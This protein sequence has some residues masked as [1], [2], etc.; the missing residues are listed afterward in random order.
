MRHLHLILVSLLLLLLSAC[1]PSG[2]NEIIDQINVALDKEGA[3]EAIA[4]H[5][6]TDQAII[7]VIQK[8]HRAQQAATSQTAV[9]FDTE[10]IFHAADSLA[11]QI[12]SPGLSIWTNTQIGFYYYR[13]SQLE[14]A[15]PYFLKSSKRIA[16]TAYKALIDPADCFV[17]NAYFFGNIGDNVQSID[18]LSQALLFVDTS[19]TDYA[20]IQF[21]L[22]GEYLS[23]GDYT[24]AEQH[25]IRSKNSAKQR[26]PIRYAKALGE[27]ALLAMEVGDLAEAETLLREDIQLS[28]AHGDERNTMFARIRLARIYIE[29]RAWEAAKLQLEKAEEYVRSRSN[30]T[31]FD[32]EITLL[33]LTI[34]T[35]LDDQAAQ[36]VLHRHLQSTAELLKETDGEKAVMRVNLAL[37]RARAEN[38]IL[39]Q[40][41]KLQQSKMN[42]AALLAVCLLLVVIALFL[43]RSKKQALRLQ[44]LKFERAVTKFQLDKMKSESKYAQAQQTI[45]SYF[46]FLKERNAAIDEL[47]AVVEQFQKSS[48]TKSK[49]QRQKLEQLMEEHLMTEE[50]WNR[51]KTT[52]IM[53][54]AEFYTQVAQ[55]LPSI[56]ESQLRIVLLQKLGLNNHGMANLLGVGQDSIKKAKQRLR[57]KYGHRYDQLFDS[58]GLETHPARHDVR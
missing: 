10:A 50:N 36:L 35:E 4:V 45:Q 29:R 28:Q 12:A 5:N 3:L 48:S 9:V 14:K 41:A 31:G 18:Y 23:L 54:H 7:A 49:D 34:A 43:R 25:F 15:F 27:L 53:E 58:P 32:Q 44:E 6:H 26:D 19:T 38:D 46:T 20:A 22:G 37:Q 11:D 52:F 57:K 47:K 13:L 2:S 33:K 39:T 24:Q 51:F 55:E 1:R 40:K 21:A 42:G 16:T 30:L 17:K 56:T 8:I